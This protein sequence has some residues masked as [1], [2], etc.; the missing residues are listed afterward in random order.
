MCSSESDLICAT[1][2]DRDCLRALVCMGRRRSHGVHQ[3]ALAAILAEVPEIAE[4]RIVRVSEL[5]G[6]HHPFK[7]GRHEVFER[8][9]I[10]ACRAHAR[11]RFWQVWRMPV[12]NLAE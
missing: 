5:P 8:G 11:Q 10:E 7:C 2:G 9:L 6:F 1:T 3:A 4:L 12:D